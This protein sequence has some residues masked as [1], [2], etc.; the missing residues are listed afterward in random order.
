[1]KSSLKAKLLQCN[2]FM[3]SMPGVPCV[4]YPHWKEYKNEINAMILARKAA[5]VHSESPVSDQCDASG[6]RATVTGTKGTLI[7]ELGN[8]VSSSQAGY[9]KAASGTGYAIWVKT[10]TN[11]APTLIVSPGSQTYKTES[12]KVTMTAV[13][14][15]GTPTIYYTLD[16]TNPKN[17]STK[18]K[19]SSPLTITGTVTL[20]AYATLSGV[21]SEVQT[22]TYTY[23]APQVTPITVAF[24]KPASWSKVYLYSWTDKGSVTEYTGKWP[25][26]QMTKVNASGMYYHQFDASL[27][28]INFIFNN[29]SG[30]QSSDLRTDEDVC[31]GWEAGDAKLIDC[32]GTDVEDVVS[33][34]TPKL[35]INQ[36]M[37][38][39]LGQ[40]VN[41]TYR[42]IVIQNGNK[43]L[44]L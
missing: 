39:M 24:Q 27:K 33:P 17:S 18:K 22:H 16:G 35:D 19:Y 21:D 37:Y 4:F 1:M 14:T 5:G 31:Y 25:G 12:L 23:Q 6:Y 42:G 11:A 8:R 20:K 40:P 43:Y 32:P 10:S 26:T 7:L 9:T 28:E 2:A 29:G 3:L 13:A 41:A 38:N 34:V 30:T 36:P 44:I 15:N